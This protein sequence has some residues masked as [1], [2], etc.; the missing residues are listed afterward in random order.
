VEITGTVTPGYLQNVRKVSSPSI[1]EQWPFR[2]PEGY[3]EGFYKELVAK[4]GTH[5]E[6]DVGLTVQ[7]YPHNTV[8]GVIVPEGEDPCPRNPHRSLRTPCEAT[9]SRRGYARDQHQGILHVLSSP[10]Y[11]KT[12]TA[13]QSGKLWV[14]IN[15]AD[16]WRWD[17]LGIFFMKLTKR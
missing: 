9:E 17:N 6:D 15:D 3:E 16:E 12:L 1:A 11:P 13:K 8:I 10:H 5:Y 4:G 14:T 2:G 7:G